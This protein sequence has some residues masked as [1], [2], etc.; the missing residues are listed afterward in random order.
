MSESQREESPYGPVDFAHYVMSIA[1]SAMIALGKLPDPESGKPNI[2]LATARHLIDV[3]SMLEEKTKG[4]LD[5]T[6]QKLVTSLLYDLRL[7]FVE[8]QRK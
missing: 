4:N 3:L 1:S 7:S 6:E 2:E 8:A 5:A